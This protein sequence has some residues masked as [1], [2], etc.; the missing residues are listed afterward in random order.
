MLKPGDPAPPFDLACALDGRIA[1]CSLA[2]ISTELVLIFFYPNDFSFICPTEVAGFNDALKKFTAEDTA[3]VSLSIDSVDS[4]LRWAR[5]LGG[6]AYPLLADPDGNLARAYG[7]F[8]DD[9]KV[10][11]RATFILDSKRK[12][13]YSLSCPLNVGRSVSETL[14]I[15]R[16]IRTGRLCPAD[17][18]PGVEFGP[19]DRDF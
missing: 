11:L 14:R 15:V 9:Q 10:A 12:V 3:V 6:I 8:D 1:R 16:A 7:V 19:T 5:E 17:W 4:H 2:K 13:A 18:K